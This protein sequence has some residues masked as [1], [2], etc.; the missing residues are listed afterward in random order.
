MMVLPSLRPTDM[1]SAKNLTS[2]IEGNWTCSALEVF[3]PFILY[4]PAFYLDD[5]ENLPQLVRVQMGTPSQ[6]TRWHPEFRFASLTGYVH[7]TWLKALVAIKEIS[8]SLFPEDDRHISILHI[9]ERP[10][11]SISGRFHNSRP[12]VFLFSTA[13]GALRWTRARFDR[14]VRS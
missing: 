10:N 1:E 9:L 11:N 8:K 3:I 13:Y 14:R 5:A 2:R 12:R 6:L 7:M 4:K